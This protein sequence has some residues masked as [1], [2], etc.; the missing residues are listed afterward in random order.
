MNSSER[1]KTLDDLQAAVTDLLLSEAISEEDKLSI[2]AL[3]L[4]EITEEKSL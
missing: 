2:L 3:S 4:K 1:E